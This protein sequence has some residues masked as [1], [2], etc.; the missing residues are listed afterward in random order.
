[1]ISPRARAQAYT[2]YILIWD[3]VD[4]IHPQLMLQSPNLVPAAFERYAHA[5]AVLCRWVR[6][7]DAVARS[8]Y[9]L[10]PTWAGLEDTYV[11]KATSEAKSPAT[12]IH[13]AAMTT[14]K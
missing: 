11:D 14:T 13:A 8:A 4:L 6:A 2:A 7:V 9:V 1:M 5:A 10:G 12:G 3:F